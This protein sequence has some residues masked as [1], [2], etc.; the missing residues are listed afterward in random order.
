MLIK[1][2]IIWP[3]KIRLCNTLEEESNLNVC[4]SHLLTT[5]CVSSAREKANHCPSHVIAEMEI[6]LGSLLQKDLFNRII[7]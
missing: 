3:I 6:Q 1:V 4:V 7:R 5:F 2:S